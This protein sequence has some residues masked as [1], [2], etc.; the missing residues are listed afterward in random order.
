MILLSRKGI[1]RYSHSEALFHVDLT[2]PS[3]FTFLH[4][5]L[6]IWLSQLL[7]LHQEPHGRSHRKCKL[8]KT[9]WKHE[10]KMQSLKTSW[11]Q[12]FSVALWHVE[13]VQLSTSFS[14]ATS[15]WASQSCVEFWFSGNL[16]DSACFACLTP[17][18]S[19]LWWFTWK[20]TCVHAS[21]HPTKLVHFC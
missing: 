6:F 14:D 7:Q 15:R 8:Q 2:Q 3:P 18:K 11:W 20:P 4:F 21:R 12:W 19:A 17:K 16:S 1:L 9:T 5:C 10:E 13:G